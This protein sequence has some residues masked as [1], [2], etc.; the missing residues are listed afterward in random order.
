[1]SKSDVSIN[2]N[3]EDHQV[4]LGA[5]APNDSRPVLTGVYV[6]PWAKGD[7][8]LT[9]ADGFVLVSVVVPAEYGKDFAGTIVP[10]TAFKEAAKYTTG[11]MLHL[12]LEAQVVSWRT[13]DGDASTPFIKGTFPS[14]ASIV[15][16]LDKMWGPAA[17]D[18]RWQAA[19]NGDLMAKTQKALGATLTNVLLGKTP[20]SPYLMVAN[21]GFA[22]LMPMFV[23]G[24]SRDFSEV[25]RVAPAFM[26][27][28]VADLELQVDKLEAAAVTLRN[29]IATLERT[30]K[31]A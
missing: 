24:P 8:R 11:P 21:H 14:W 25:E 31:A 2:V 29:E 7:V 4:W 1:L 5:A 13:K 18:G 15:G 27:R 10:A 19:F 20:G 23:Q 6:E 17:V 28:R 30:A 22:M 26:D 9:A 12:D 3:R 16:D